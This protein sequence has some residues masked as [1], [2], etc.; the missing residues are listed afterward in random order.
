MKNLLSNKN[1]ILKDYIDFYCKIK[2]DRIY[3]IGSGTSYNS[4]AVAAP[5][6]EKIL[7]VEVKTVAP[8]ALGNIYGNKPLAIAVS[9]SGRSTNTIDAINKLKKI[10]VPVITLTDPK[11]SPVGHV[12]D[13]A[14]HLAANNELIGPR[15]RGY[16]ATVLT[17]Y[18]MA[19]EVGLVCKTI[20]ESVYNEAITAYNS[21]FNN[22]DMYFKACQDFYDLHYDNLCKI[23]KYMFAG[24]D[25]SAMVAVESALKVIETVIFPAMGFEYDEFL[26]G[27]LCC[28]N[29]DL[30]VF[31]F[32]THD[33]DIGRMLKS[34][35]L[36]GKIT[37]NCYLISNDPSIKGDKI[38]YLAPENPEYTSVFT[39]ILF[40]QLISAKLTVDMA[41]VRHPGVKDIFD[42][43]GTKASSGDAKIN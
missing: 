20:D 4:C 30:G 33:D 12:G 24:K 42:N 2:P 19:L 29:E 34:A 31:L 40:P 41:R 21:T 18:L 38:L 3:L 16:T 9:Q 26:H 37:E 28:A 25:N 39:N 32:L 6:M 14:V 8:S 5:F 43:M 15:T 35:D 36:I 10:G 17:L 1:E 7:G 11:D 27:P 22:A 23:R 13:L